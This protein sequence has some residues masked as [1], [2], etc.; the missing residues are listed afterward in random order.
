MAIYRRTIHSV[1][2]VLDIGF[3]MLPTFTFR[4]RQTWHLTTYGL[5]TIVSVW[6]DDFGV[7]NR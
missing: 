5:P 4:R 6:K 2:I 3:R 7:Q 1:T